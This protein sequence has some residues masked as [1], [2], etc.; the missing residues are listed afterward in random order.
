VNLLLFFLCS[1]F[2]FLFFRH[3][4]FSNRGGE[5]GAGHISV[6]LLQTDCAEKLK[7]KK[8]A[9]LRFQDLS[10]GKEEQVA[11]GKTADGS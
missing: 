7:G 5:S 10:T 8:S 11:A 6:R 9:V 4:D 2:L 3:T 1:F